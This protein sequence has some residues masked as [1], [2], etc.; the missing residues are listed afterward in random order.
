MLPCK[1]P[2]FDYLWWSYQ[3]ISLPP[4]TARPTQLSILPR[5]VNEY[6]IIPGLTPG[7]RRWGLLPSTTTG[8]FTDGV[9]EC[10][11]VFFYTLPPWNLCSTARRR[12][13]TWEVPINDV[14]YHSRCFCQVPSS[15]FLKMSCI[16][17][18]KTPKDENSSEHKLE[19]KRYDI[20]FREKMIYIDIGYKSAAQH[21]DEKMLKMR[22]LL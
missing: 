5:S 19:R 20:W 16:P 21:T 22:R 9:C 14:E 15:P 3:Q 12:R 13:H 7:H 6:R 4:R 11:F 1:R 10:V 17:P 18:P 2:G 8:G